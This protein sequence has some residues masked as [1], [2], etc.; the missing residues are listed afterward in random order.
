MGAIAIFLIQKNRHMLVG[1]AVP[2]PRLAHVVRILEEDAVV[3][4]VHDVKALIVG[5]HNGR[6]KA[7]IN[8]DGDVLA[9]RCMCKMRRHLE[10]LQ[11]PMEL[12]EVEAHMVEY[13]KELVNTIGDEV[14]RLEGI[15]RKEVM[16]PTNAARDL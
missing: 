13:S 16:I 6:F 4:S 8:F 1:Q 7:E 15:I 3:S 5:S 2:A 11:H 9:R 10:A 12:K 14:D